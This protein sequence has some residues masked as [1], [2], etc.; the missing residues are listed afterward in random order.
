MVLVVSSSVF[1]EVPEQP[2][3]EQPTLTAAATEAI[4]EQPALLVL[5]MESATELPNLTVAES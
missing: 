2:A 4:A 5:T 1:P 3:A